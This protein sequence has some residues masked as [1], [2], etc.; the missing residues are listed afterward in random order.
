MT[1]S[2]LLSPVRLSGVQLAHRLVMSP[3][4]R[5]VSSAAVPPLAP[6]G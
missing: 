5:L 6:I 4:T 3:M 1:L 2:P